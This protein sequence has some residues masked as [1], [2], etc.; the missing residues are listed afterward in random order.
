MNERDIVRKAY[1]LLGPFQPELVFPLS[2]HGD[3]QRRFQYSWF[4]DNPWLE[5]SIALDKAYCFPCFL[6]DTK[7]SKN[8]TFTVEGFRNWMRVCVSDNMFVKHVGGITSPH[9]AAM[10]K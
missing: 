7:N 10:Q 4:K 3:Q 9:N 1:I 8:H 6:F 5:Y 2:E